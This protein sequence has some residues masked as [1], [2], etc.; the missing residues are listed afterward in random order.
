M[1]ANSIFFAMSSPI[2]FHILSPSG[3]IHEQYIDGA[4]RRL[5]AWGYRVSEGIY[6][7]TTFGRFAGTKEQRLSDMKDAL[8]DPTIDYILCARGGY[9]LQQLIDRIAP[10][11]MNRPLPTIIGFSDITCL[12]S[13]MA[14]RGVLSLHGLMCKHL[15]EPESGEIC[16]RYW[17]QAV[18]GQ[19]IEYTIPSHTLNRQGQAEGILVGGNLSVLYG[20]QGTPYSL[21]EILRRH[22]EQGLQ[23]LL[24]IEDV[25]ERHYHIDRM[26]QNL[27]LSGVLEGISG[28]VVG[29]FSECDDDPLMQETVYDTILSS[30]K[31]YDY[32]VLFDFPAGHVAYNIPFRLGVRT[33]LSVSSFQNAFDSSFRQSQLV[34]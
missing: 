19:T 10:L 25:C 32:P 11:T 2:H 12:H 34:R 1:Q 18:E 30:V 21:M 22:K 9:G 33:E 5:K 3:K 26:M 29:Q 31:D 28:L 14:L 15:A 17:Q 23:T 27:R 6:V 13:L 16:L 8:Q 7:R 24:F 20:L 4:T